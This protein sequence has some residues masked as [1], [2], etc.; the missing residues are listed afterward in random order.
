MDCIYSQHLNFKVGEDVKCTKEYESNL[1]NTVQL[2]EWMGQSKNCESCHAQ[3]EE[4]CSTYSTSNDS[5][6]IGI[7]NVDIDQV[8]NKVEEIIA[9]ANCDELMV[10]GVRKMLEEWLGMRLSKYHREIKALIVDAM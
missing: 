10:K 3:E 5:A 6:T 8:H 1:I 7:P 2:S 4:C 9:S